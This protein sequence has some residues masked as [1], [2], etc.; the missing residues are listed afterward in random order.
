MTGPVNHEVVNGLNP[1]RD[2]VSLA[3]LQA[4]YYS[5]ANGLPSVADGDIDNALRDNLLLDDHSVASLA[6]TFHER[7]AHPEDLLMAKYRIHLPP[8][9]FSKVRGNDTALTN[10]DTHVVGHVGEGVGVGEEDIQS[11]SDDT[12]DDSAK[13]DKVAQVDVYRQGFWDFFVEMNEAGVSNDELMKMIW[14]KKK[15]D[16]TKL[17]YI[18]AVTKFK[19]A[20]QAGI[21]DEDIPMDQSF[22]SIDTRYTLQQ[23]VGMLSEDTD[24][25]QKYPY[26]LP[27]LAALELFEEGLITPS[28]AVNAQEL[29][30]TS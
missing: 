14:E 28:S 11:N 16:P 21:V 23:L 18:K 17:D 10:H 8:N 2:A 15:S 3:A 1:R 7:L 24:F 12:V 30:S 22:D 6:T 9:A 5:V 19:L 25:A 4:A 29:P 27:R 20:R 26:Y 13:K